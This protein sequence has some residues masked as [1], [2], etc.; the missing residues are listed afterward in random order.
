MKTLLSISVVCAIAFV[1]VFASALSAAPVLAA[2]ANAPSAAECAAPT[3]Q[4]MMNECAYEDFLVASAEYAASNKQYA[5]RLSS[6]Q[7]TL[8]RR[9]QSAWIA[10]QTA[11]CEFES[12]A[13]QGGSAR[14]MSRWQ[15]ASRMT[16]ARAIEVVNLSNCKEG[17]IS[18]PRFKR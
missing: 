2:A 10:Y 9:S 3:T 5:D 1:F 7:R 6:T 15:C 17:D 16:R 14:A 18:C 11:A 12:S 13:L 8:F 4:K